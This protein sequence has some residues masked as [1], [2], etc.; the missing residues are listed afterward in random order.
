MPHSGFWAWLSSANSNILARPL[1]QDLNS[2]LLSLITYVKNVENIRIAT[3]LQ[4][5][6][7]AGLSYSTL[8]QI[9][10]YIK[11]HQITKYFGIQVFAVPV[12]GRFSLSPLFP[13]KKN[14]KRD[15]PENIFYSVHIALLNIFPKPGL[16]RVSRLVNPKFRFFWDTFLK[17]FLHILGTLPFIERTQKD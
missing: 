12:K 1:A 15:P 4:Q 10:N 5:E 11:L 8:G 16:V 14:M 7:K 6:N 17:M 3:I 13:P 9:L 2:L